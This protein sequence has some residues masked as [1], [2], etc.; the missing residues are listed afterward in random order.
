M[1]KLKH[2]YTAVHQNKTRRFP[3]LL[4]LLKSLQINIQILLTPAKESGH[5]EVKLGH[6]H[7]ASAI[8]WLVCEYTNL[9]LT[10]RLGQ[11][12]V[13]SFNLNFRSRGKPWIAISPTW[14]VQV[15]IHRWWVRSE[16]SIWVFCDVNTR[17][18]GYINYRSPVNS[19]HLKTKYY[20]KLNVI[21][22]YYFNT[23]I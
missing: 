10:Q 20:W 5:P 16:Y 6:F 12:T 1:L 2:I 4:R 11:R 23:K 3:L 9:H 14:A 17:P 7:T 18:F 13:K 19:I 22:I 15:W 8:P 21:L